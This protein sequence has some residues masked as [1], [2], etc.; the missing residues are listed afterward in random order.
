MPTGC[1]KHYTSSTE[2]VVAGD[3]GYAYSFVPLLLETRHRVF[4]VVTITEAIAGLGNNT[5]LLHAAGERTLDA[6][7]IE[8]GSCSMVGLWGG[9]RNRQLRRRSQI[10]GV[11]YII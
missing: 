10:N 2:V 3:R 1:S 6:P 4:S 8:G 5:G 7:G 9:L 11:S